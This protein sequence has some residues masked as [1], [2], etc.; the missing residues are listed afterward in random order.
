MHPGTSVISDHLQCDFD[1]IQASHYIEQDIESFFLH[2]PLVQLEGFL[3]MLPQAVIL[4][5]GLS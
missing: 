4:L 1:N 3:P 5:Y 2:F